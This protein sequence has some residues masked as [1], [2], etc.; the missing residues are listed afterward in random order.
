[1][2]PIYV[3]FIVPVLFTSCVTK[4]KFVELETSKKSL[5]LKYENLQKKSS[6]LELENARQS[7]E[8]IY[9]NKKIDS[10]KTDTSYLAGQLRNL[11]KNYNLLNDSYEMLRD[12]MNKQLEGKEKQIIE[13]QNNL[14]KATQKV[15]ER[16]NELL[17]LAKDLHEQKVEF[18]QVKAQYEKADAELQRAQNE[19][20][21]KSKDLIKL[22]NALK[23]QDSLVKAL[24][25]TV[26]NAFLG[27]KD[28][29]LSVNI[30]NG[31]VYLSLEEKLLFQTGSI[32]VDKKGEEAL[33]KLAKILEKDTTITVMVEGHTDDVP[34]LKPVGGIKDNWDLSVLR[35]TSIVRILLK[36]G[37]IDPKRIIP[38]GRGPYLPVDPRPTPE[39]RAK[40]RRIEIILTPELDKIFKALE[41]N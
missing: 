36:N 24:K 21:N 20:E 1:M 22:Q 30:K 9:L 41:I 13:L 33:I 26:T 35:A 32:Y 25:Q 18:E 31:K 19:L 15:K 4:K 34:Y 8:I 39:A 3:L 37:N 38:A 29:G 17:L 10:L 5:E 27:Y 16:E 12:K 40:N 11:K 2:K 6:E 23:K 7:Q 28:K 14:I